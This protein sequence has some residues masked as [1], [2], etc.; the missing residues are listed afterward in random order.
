MRTHP[1]A[2]ADIRLLDGGRSISASFGVAVFP[3]DAPYAAGLIRNADRALYRAKANGRDRVEVF[4][5]DLSSDGE[6]LD[7]SFPDPARGSVSLRE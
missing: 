3:E 1:A 4:S 6:A 5:L 2:F 7:R